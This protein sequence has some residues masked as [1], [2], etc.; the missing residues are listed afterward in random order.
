MFPQS[1]FE[2]QKFIKQFSSIDEKNYA[3][4]LLLFAV[5]LEK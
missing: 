2:M 5:K 4:K 3:D 1:S